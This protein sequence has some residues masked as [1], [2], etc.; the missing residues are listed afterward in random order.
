MT[1]AEL[2]EVQDTLETWSALCLKGLAE[3]KENIDRA[4]IKK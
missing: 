4:G 2:L 1:P 3:M